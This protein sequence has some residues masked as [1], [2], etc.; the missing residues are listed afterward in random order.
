MAGLGGWRARRAW[1]SCRDGAPAIRIDLDWIGL[2]LVRDDPRRPLYRQLAQIVREASGPALRGR[3]PTERQWASGL[4]LARVTV[5]KALDELAREGVI[6]RRQGAGTF[7]RP[8]RP[9]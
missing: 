6:E 3:L 2:R 1:V 8:V 5:R 9:A 7:L 4:R